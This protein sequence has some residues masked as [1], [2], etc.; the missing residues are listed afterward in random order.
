VFDVNLDGRND[1]ALSTQGNGFSL[2]HG[3]S[4]P[5]IHTENDYDAD[6]RS[7][8]SIFRPSLGDWFIKR[9]TL[10]YSQ[11]HWGVATD[12]LVPA[13]YDGD[14]KTDIAVWRENGYGDPNR[15]Y[16]FILQSSNN[17]FRQEQLGR[18]GDV[19][20]VV[21]DGRT[22]FAVFRPANGV[23]Y[24][25]S[26]SNGTPIY[27]QWGTSTDSLVPADYNMAMAWQ[28]W[29]SIDPLKGVGISRNTV[30]SML[31]IRYTAQ[32]A[33]WLFLQLRN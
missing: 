33:M 30:C 7:D 29:Q 13:D 2:Y 8:L 19:P 22:D 14:F 16:F 18:T 31:T 23:W 24:I 12:K 15:F 9:S 20:S 6:S 32:G 21:G 1:L 27:R 3:N 28:K 26:S 4:N 25:I 5:F 17:T 10:G 11:Q